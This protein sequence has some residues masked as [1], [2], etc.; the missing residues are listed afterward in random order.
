MIPRA[1]TC[2]VTCKLRSLC[3]HFHRLFHRSEVMISLYVRAN[4]LRPNAALPAGWGA[5]RLRCAPHTCACYRPDNSGPRGV[6]AQPC[7][8]FASSPCVDSEL[9]QWLLSYPPLETRQLQ[10]DVSEDVLDAM[11][12]TISGMLG[13]LPSANWTVRTTATGPPPSRP[14]RQTAFDAPVYI[15]PARRTWR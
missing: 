13:L 11:R 14:P 15:F 3:A 12:R 6:S 8:Y 10:Q 4:L 9:T 1:R 2:H 5:R 7:Q